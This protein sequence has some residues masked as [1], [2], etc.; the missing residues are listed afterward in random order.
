M[1]ATLP[2]SLPDPNFDTFGSVMSPS[3]LN[4]SES[5]V[6]FPHDVAALPAIKMPVAN[7]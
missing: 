6:C 4:Q 2:F 5:L 1:I 3:Q 7:D